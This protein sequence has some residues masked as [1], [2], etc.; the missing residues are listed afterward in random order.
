MSEIKTQNVSWN[1][2]KVDQYTDI[3]TGYTYITLPG[4]TGKLAESSGASWTINDINTLT[5]IYNAANLSTLTTDEVRALF[6]RSGRLVYNKVRTDTI[7]D[8]I[9]YSDVQTFELWMGGMFNNRIPG[10]V[11]PVDGRSVNDNGKSTSTNTFNTSVPKVS[12]FQTR[13]SGTP[14]VPSTFVDANVQ[15]ASTGNENTSRS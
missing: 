15:L 3:S 10:A 1:N 14:V 12:T 7:N 13:T 6:F 8:R 9:L 11:N 5:R 4:Q 2:I